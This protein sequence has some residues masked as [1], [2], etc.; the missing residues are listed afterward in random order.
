MYP[1]SWL[2]FPA[3]E[4]WPFVGDVCCVPLATQARCSRGASH[5]GSVGPSVGPEENRL[6]LKHYKVGHVKRTQ[7]MGASLK[8]FS[9]TKPETT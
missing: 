4:K 3:L 1:V 7:E 8:A 6:L 2:H 9:L 5:V